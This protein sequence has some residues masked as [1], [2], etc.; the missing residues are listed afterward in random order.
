MHRRLSAIARGGALAILVL[1]LHGA[2]TGCGVGRASNQEKISKT[3]DTY[4]RALADGD[5][6]KSCAQLTRR[7]QRGRRLARLRHPR[8][9][10]DGGTL[11]PERR[12][13]RARQSRQRV[14][15]RLR[16]HARA[17][18]PVTNQN[19][20]CDPVDSDLFAIQC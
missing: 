11:Q 10:G 18:A 16:L 1:A 5:T 20:G 7:A 3:V 12:S 17:D 9:H 13:P 4:L 8:Q 6:A 2:L 14:A 15:N 19:E